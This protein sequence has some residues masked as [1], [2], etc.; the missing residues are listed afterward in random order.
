[1]QQ[2]ITISVKT[3]KLDVVKLYA[4]VDRYLGIPYR[5]GGDSE[6]GIDCSAF[7]RRVYR[8]NNVELPRTSMEQSH[9]GFGVG[10]APMQPGDLVFFDPSIVGRISHV[11]VYLGHGEFAHASSSKGVTRSNIR[12]KY[13]TKRFVK[14]N[15]LF[16]M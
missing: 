13:Y 2:N 3:G 5:Y 7:T 11:G 12:E 14:A 8:V 9:V 4:A 6:T 10:S 16:E 15:R 1:M